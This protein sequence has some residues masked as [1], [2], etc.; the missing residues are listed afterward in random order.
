M[1][2]GLCGSECGLLPARHEGHLCYSFWFMWD[3]LNRCLGAA[4][5]E[6][7]SQG[8][9]PHADALGS[10]GSSVPQT[11]FL[12]LKCSRLGTVLCKMKKRVHFSL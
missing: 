4:T 6:P 7:A 12:T 5:L 2:R 8:L 10:G 3:H 9:C 11:R 1:S